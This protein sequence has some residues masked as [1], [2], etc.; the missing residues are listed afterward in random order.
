V[1]LCAL[2]TTVFRF[3]GIFGA[4]PNLLLAF[5]VCAALL[6][7]SP[8]GGAVGLLCG[9]L[10]D[11]GGYGAFGVHALMYLYIGAGL[12][13]VCGQFYRVRSVVAFTFAFA[14]CFTYGFLYYFFSY[15]IW[16]YGTLWFA[17]PRKI[18][19]ESVSTALAAVLILPLLTRINRRFGAR[20]A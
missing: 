12:G 11:V 17:L 10:A 19:P 7:G 4:R 16:G 18:L 1:L 13:L 3:F 20:G 9:I 8:E 6:R 15:F 14:A 5:T 2:Q